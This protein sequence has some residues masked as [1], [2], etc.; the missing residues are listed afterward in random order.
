[1]QIINHL[2]E[3]LVYS[4]TTDAHPWIYFRNLLLMQLINYC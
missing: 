2:N 3:E 1:M 4:V